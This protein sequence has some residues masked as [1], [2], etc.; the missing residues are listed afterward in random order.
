LKIAQFEKELA[1]KSKIN[2]LIEIKKSKARETLLKIEYELHK[3]VLDACKENKIDIRT[4]LLHKE[5]K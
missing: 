1:Q 4:P 2:A 3:T 5:I